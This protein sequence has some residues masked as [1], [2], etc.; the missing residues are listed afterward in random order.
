MVDFFE[1]MIENL[2]KLIHLGHPSRNNKK[3]NKMLRKGITTIKR[4]KTQTKMKNAIIFQ[5]PRYV[6]T[7]C[8]RVHDFESTNWASTIKK[9]KN[10]TPNKRSMLWWRRK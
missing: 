1:K 7:Y 3:N 6:W 10:S 4:L 8:G 5:A 9:G 2:E